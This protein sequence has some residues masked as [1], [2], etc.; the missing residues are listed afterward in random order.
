MDKKSEGASSEAETASH[1]QGSGSVVSSPL[2]GRK[3]NRMSLVSNYSGIV[4]D[5]DI[6]T[7]RYVNPEVKSESQ[8]PLRMPSVKTISTRKTTT[9]S[10]SIKEPYSLP[11]NRAVSGR[12]RTPEKESTTTLDLPIPARSPRRPN[13]GIFES[14]TPD[15]SVRLQ[16]APQVPP[17]TSA[18]PSP[19]P[20]P[21]KQ[22]FNET[23]QQYVQPR[24]P[25]TTNYGSRH[26]SINSQLDEIMSE[27]EIIRKDNGLTAA[28]VPVDFTNKS[29]PPSPTRENASLATAGSLPTDASMESNEQL[30]TTNTTGDSF[31][32]AASE[33]DPD[34]IDEGYA[35]ADNEDEVMTATG[36]SGPLNSRTLGSRP[37]TIRVLGTAT[38]ADSTIV[39]E[40]SSLHSE[41]TA[42]NTITRTLDPHSRSPSKLQGFE[43][44]AEVAAATTKPVKRTSTVRR[45]QSI[46]RSSMRSAYGQAQVAR[47]PS[48]Q[49]K[50]QNSKTSSGSGSG[51]SSSKKSMKP[52]SYNT[53]ARL[54][55]ATD[56][57]VIGQ[58]FAT[59]D[60]PKEERYLLEKIVS[61]ISKLTANMMVNPNRYDQS[62]ARLER[63][64]NVLEGFD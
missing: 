47:S 42:A 14:S 35:A 36:A 44:T 41:N 39:A 64:L 22:D 24:I 56:G 23:D 2:P 15:S 21:I 54:L 18:L 57:I 3:F 59:L 16:N 50:K 33:S 48:P 12:L 29:L 17:P 6:D 1:S 11:T 43:T 62:C 9:D 61:S 5:A 60:M 34:W 38:P 27:V 45:G 7:I 28:Q 26:A 31:H 8:H 37:S 58:E 10:G 49:H 30:H 32:T 51:S 55:N 52:F 19:A 40:T 53:L 46:A 63:V 25:S 20:S 13:S 4:Q